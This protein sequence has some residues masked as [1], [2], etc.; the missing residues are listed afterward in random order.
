M[1]KA[2]KW[3]EIL[4]NIDIFVRSVQGT[5]YRLAGLVFED[6]STEG[7]FFGVEEFRECLQASMSKYKNKPK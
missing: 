6:N 2:S 4:V 5:P 7:M 1:P 3:N